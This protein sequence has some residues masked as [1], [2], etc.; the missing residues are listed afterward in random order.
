MLVLW[1]IYKRVCFITVLKAVESQL[2]PH[3]RKAFAT[4]RTYP[5]ATEAVDRTVCDVDSMRS[6]A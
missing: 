6:G 2:R 5:G 4:L 3:T 1:Q